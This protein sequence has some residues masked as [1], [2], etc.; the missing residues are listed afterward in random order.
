M[1][2]ERAPISALRLARFCKAARLWLLRAGG[3]L[4]AVAGLSEPLGRAIDAAIRPFTKKMIWVVLT[5]IA[6]MAQAHLPTP[7]RQS[8]GG[9]PKHARGNMNRSVFGARLRKL[10][11]A[12]DPRAIIAALLMLLQNAEAH[13]LRLARRLRNGL[14][15]RLGGFALEPRAARLGAL[16]FRAPAS[17][18]TS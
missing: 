11:R 4:I 15:R 10:A 13:A 2:L 3:W 18:D 5:L 7:P 1:R 14:A 6:L 12:K 16:S 9:R 17:A 8:A